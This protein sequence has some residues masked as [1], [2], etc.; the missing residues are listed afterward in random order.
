[1]SLDR[2][3]GPTPTE[4]SSSTHDDD[5]LTQTIQTRM[6]V[7]PAADRYEREADAVADSVVESLAR[8]AQLSWDQE[9]SRVARS[10]T[11]A[12]APEAGSQGGAGVETEFESEVESEP[13]VRRSTAPA[14]E[15]PPAGDRITRIRRADSAM[16]TGAIGAAGG[17][18]DQDS[19]AQLHSRLRKGRPLDDSVRRR[20]EPAFGEDFSRVR[21]HDD[22]PARELNSKLS[23]EAFTVGSDIFFS[24]SAPDASSK[25]G[26]RLLAHELTHVVQQGTS[27]KR[28]LA[29]R[30]LSREADDLK[31]MR[32]EGGNPKSDPPKA[33]RNTRFQ[34]DAEDLQDPELGTE[35]DVGGAGTGKEATALE[36]KA[37]KMVVALHEYR[38]GNDRVHRKK[39]TRIKKRSR[40]IAKLKGGLAIA[41]SN[42]AKGAER[43]GNKGKHAGLNLGRSIGRAFGKSVKPNAN[44]KKQTGANT[45]DTA[46]GAYGAVDTEFIEP[47]FTVKLIGTTWVPMLTHLKGTYG[48]ITSPLPAGLA[49]IGGPDANESRQQIIDLLELDGDDWYMSKAVNAHESIHEDHLLDAL[50]IVGNDIA[51]LF[52]ALT[53]DQATYPK[54]KDAIAAI[55]L[56]PGYNAIMNL[57]NPNDSQIR[58]LWD[59]EYVNQIDRD[60]YGPTQNAEADVVEPTIDKINRWRKKQKKVRLAKVWTC[61]N[62]DGAVQVPKGRTNP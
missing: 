57:A 50:D 55:K 5:E 32:A 6:R 26:Q 53:V 52:A 34:Y 7:G 10:S 11:G 15:A 28:R 38:T 42:V 24:G 51:Q 60:H 18:L 23:A 30:A 33:G 61:T 27:T 47:K 62:D 40:D 9:G 12:A 3:C 17:A 54:K 8:P 58:D 48:K 37:K 1:M 25:P 20:L 16:A 46:Q 21:V 43:L 14:G 39:K 49:E 13:R 44:V 22:R 4:R 59:N 36:P 41:G 19:E 29:R 2:E 45:Q 31:R 35:G 56:L